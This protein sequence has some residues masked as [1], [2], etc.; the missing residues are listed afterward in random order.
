MVEAAV[1]LQWSRPAQLASARDGIL[2][3][4]KVSD[5]NKTKMLRPVKQQQ[6]CIT[7]KNSSVATRTFAIKNNLVQKH[8]K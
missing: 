2:K 4:P 6:E 8:Q 5:G 1:A 3:A 7:E